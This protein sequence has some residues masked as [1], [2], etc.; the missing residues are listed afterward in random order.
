[1]RSDHPFDTK[2]LY[3][4]LYTEG[5][6]SDYA[7]HQLD[8]KSVQQSESI[9]RSLK[10]LKVA[11]TAI[12]VEVGAGLGGNNAV[13]PLWLGIEYSET[14]VAR[15]KKAFGPQLNLA[16]GDARALPLAD[17]SVDFLFS[18]S[19]YE[20]VPKV[21]RAFAEIERVLKPRGY[22]VI[23][24]A[25][26][27][28]SWTVKKLQQRPYSELSMLEMLGKLLIP[29]RESLVFRAITALPGR[30]YREL[31]LALGQVLPLSYTPLA[32][33]FALLSRYPHISDDDAFVSMD[34]HA[35]MAYFKSRRFRILSHESFLQRFLCRADA[36]VIQKQ[37]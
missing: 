3:D 31:R 35:A 19:T 23:H 32:P 24:P 22:A 28:R 1:M 36:V 29:I 20:H 10:A 5:D 6:I 11:D 2:S 8:E 27:C 9:R 18:F 15:G 4:K 26:N 12:V 21:E 13:H 16:Q 7:C 33:D 37:E 34:A 17:E 30:L 25:W 14:A